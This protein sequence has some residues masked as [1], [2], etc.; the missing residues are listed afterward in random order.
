MSLLPEWLRHATPLSA[1]EFDAFDR[2]MS[3]KQREEDRMAGEALSPVP[4]ATQ[5]CLVHAEPD[6]RHCRGCAADSKAAG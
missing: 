3:D 6:V 5:A 4:A 1:A 2:H